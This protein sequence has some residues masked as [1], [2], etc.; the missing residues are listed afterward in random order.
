MHK[1]ELL[2]LQF[3]PSW[4]QAALPS[5]IASA[6]A[7]RVN[8]GGAPR[9]EPVKCA[10]PMASLQDGL[11]ERVNLHAHA[12]RLIT[13]E[14]LATARSSPRLAGTRGPRRLEGPRGPATERKLGPCG[15][16]DVDGIFIIIIKITAPALLTTALP[17]PSG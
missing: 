9:S 17:L 13:A 15:G 11:S 10:V 7:L 14:D 6:R 5:W 4:G 2:G 12:A 1:D 8:A 3:K 16:G